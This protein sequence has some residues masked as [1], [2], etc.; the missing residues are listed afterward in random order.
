MT[1]LVDSPSRS[2][3]GN[4]RPWSLVML[5]KDG[6]HAE[7]RCATWAAAAFSVGLLALV[8]KDSLAHFYY[9]WT[10]DENY[11]HG[12]LVPPFC[13]YFIAQLPARAPCRCAVGSGWEASCSFRRWQ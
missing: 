1:S 13:L 8:F 3:A 11:S 12:F 6:L 2:C 9:A 4:T 10:T 7:A 5:F